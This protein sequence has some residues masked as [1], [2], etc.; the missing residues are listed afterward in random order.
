MVF[1]ALSPF[2]VQRVVQW[3]GTEVEKTKQNQQQQKNTSD[4]RN[5]KKKKKKYISYL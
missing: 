3:P 4:T 5:Q 1:I 2:P